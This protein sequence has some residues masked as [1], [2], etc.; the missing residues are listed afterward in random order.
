MRGWEWADRQTGLGM[1]DRLNQAVMLLDGL[2]GARGD[3]A[4]LLTDRALFLR[5]RLLYWLGKE[6]DGPNRAAEALRDLQKLSTKY[7]HDDLISVY[8]GQKVDLPDECDRLAPTPAAPAWSTAQ[9][10]ALCRMRQAAHWWVNERQAADGEFGGKFG[11]DVELLRWWAPLALA[12]DETVRRG[13]QRLADGVW[14]SRH[15]DAGYAR[16]VRDVEHAA[17]FVADTAPMMAALSDDPRYQDRLALSVPHFANL[18]T[19]MTPQGR[20]FFQSAWFSSSAIVTD[21]PKNRDVEYNVRAV[22]MLRYLAWRRGNPE[23]VKLLHEWSLAWVSAAMRTDKGKPRGIVPPSVRFPD[24]AINGD[25]P[26]WHRAN[27]FWDYYDWDFD[28]GGMVLDQLLFTYTLT[29]DE[30]LLEPMFA[31]LELIQSEEAGLAETKPKSPQEGSRPW[32]ADKLIRSRFFWSVV[33]QWRFLTGDRRWDDLIMRY[34]TAYARYRISGDEQHLSDGLDFILS[35]V[36]YNTPLLTTE[37]IH[38]DRVYVPGWEQ[39]KAMLTGDGMPENSSPYFAASWENTDDCFTALVA[40]AAPGRLEVQLFSHS[41]EAHDV[42]MR[43]W[44]LVPGDYLL[45]RQVEGLEAEHQTIAVETRGQRIR[46]K[47][48]SGRLLRISVTR[49]GAS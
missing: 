29:H 17:E 12:G 25:E 37:A 49:I 14:Q 30:S 32:A 9:R 35:S 44:Q 42:V 36:R 16:D 48:P 40:D 43:V 3:Q 1:S 10:E 27:M 21:P 24:E 39:L 38:T 2:L 5:A 18:W 8:L 22:R 13:W 15:V 34:G 26:T 41:L 47:L 46:V 6:G 19:G 20:R 33:G 4:D 31:E 11:D 7:P 28:V 23:A 45:G